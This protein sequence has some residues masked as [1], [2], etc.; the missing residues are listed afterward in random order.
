[1]DNDSCFTVLSEIRR[2]DMY[3]SCFTVLT[4]RRR[5]DMY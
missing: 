3:D 2:N 4:E 1:M 5:N